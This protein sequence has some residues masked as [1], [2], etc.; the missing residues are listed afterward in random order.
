MRKR[1]RCCSGCAI[2]EGDG[3]GAAAAGFGLVPV[4]E[5]DR[6]PRDVPCAVGHG[7]HAG[8]VPLPAVRGRR[9]AHL[10]VHQL[11]WH[12]QGSVLS[13]HLYLYFGY[14]MFLEI[15]YVL[16]APKY[17]FCLGL[18]SCLGILPNLVEPVDFCSSIL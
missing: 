6:V 15:Q 1:C 2:P 4:Q 12:H 3:A 9:E 10:P 11:H 17:L 14:Y 5:P 18:I 13:T 16:L 7:A 8:R